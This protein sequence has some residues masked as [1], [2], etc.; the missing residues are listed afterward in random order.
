MILLPEQE[1]M[2]VKPAPA[3][4]TLQPGQ[5]AIWSAAEGDEVFCAAGAVRIELA[6]TDA[7][8]PARVLSAGQALRAPAAGVFRA[9]GVF[10]SRG[11][12]LPS[13]REATV[14][15]PGKTK[16]PGPLGRGLSWIWN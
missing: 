13:Q 8:L 1:R 16:S 4:W 11:E 5:Q 10:A 2:P 6:G 14:A 15:A 3:N 12:L 9:E 7:P